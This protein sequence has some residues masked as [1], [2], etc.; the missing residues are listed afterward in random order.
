MANKIKLCGFFISLF[1]FQ[2]CIAHIFSSLTQSSPIFMWSNTGYFT[3]VNTESVDVIDAL[4][5]QNIFQGKDTSFISQDSIN[6]EILVVFIE[7][8]L[9]TEKV[10]ILSNAYQAQSN[11]GSLSNLRNLIENS[12]SSV[13]FPY[14]I[15]CEFRSFVSSLTASFPSVIIATEEGKSIPDVSGATYSFSKLTDKLSSNQWNI[16]NNGV[17]DLI[18][19]SFN[20]Q[21]EQFQANDVTLGNVINA[22]SGKTTYAAM[23]AGIQQPE[24]L[25][26]ARSFPLSHPLMKA[27]EGTFQQVN[28]ATAW[29]G[30]VIEA[31][32]VMVPFLFILSVGICCTF[33]IQ[34]HLK[35]D[36]EKSYLKN[37]Q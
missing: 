17:T 13:V 14:V 24:Y 26:I 28:Y 2:L 37:R 18:I 12:K 31:L 8:S 22:L 32:L 34:S 21:S 23:F 35:F 15:N 20:P 36:A 27:F 25:A 29:P 19:V 6:P 10:G 7:S 16:L 4:N 33:N 11:G 9:T 30:G 5:V 1:V 3:G